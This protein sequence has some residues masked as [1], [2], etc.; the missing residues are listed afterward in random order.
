MKGTVAFGIIVVGSTPFQRSICQALRELSDSGT[1]IFLMHG[2]RDFMLGQAFCKAAGCTLLKD[3]TVVQFNDELV[4]L[5]HGDSLCTRDVGYMKLRRWLRNPVTL[6]ILRHLPLGSRQKLARKL[7]S[8]L[9]FANRSDNAE[10]AVADPESVERGFYRF[11]GSAYESWLGIP[12]LPKLDHGSA[13]MRR[14]LPIT[15][16]SA[17]SCSPA[18]PC[19]FSP[20]TRRGGSTTRCSP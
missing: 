12:S 10:R 17:P 8:V 16:C 6:F 1:A 7:R 19:S 15:S 18:W 11:H 9:V 20:G 14:D 2:N 13:E 5:M 4:L 3:P